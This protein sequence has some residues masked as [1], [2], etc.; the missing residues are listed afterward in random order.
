MVYI[1]NPSLYAIGDQN[2]DI[3]F[4]GVNAVNSHEINIFAYPGLVNSS[5]NPNYQKLKPSENENEGS[6]E[7][8]YIS[9]VYLHDDNLN[10]VGKAKLAQPIV[11]RSENKFLFRL[12][13]DF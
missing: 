6:G 1:R 9:T 4:E 7:F 12:R 8:V 10:V 3:S 11:K 2:M 5:S 13:I